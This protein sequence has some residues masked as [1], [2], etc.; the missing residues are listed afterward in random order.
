MDR[1]VINNVRCLHVVSPLSF[2]YEFSQYCA[3]IVMEISICPLDISHQSR[4]E[5]ITS[6]RLE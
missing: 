1:V 6:C 2:L 3:F 5:I 4:S